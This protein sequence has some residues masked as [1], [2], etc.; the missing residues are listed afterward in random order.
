MIIKVTI[1]EEEKRDILVK[2]IQESLPDG[3]KLTE[4]YLGIG[5]FT[6][7]KN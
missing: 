1:T 5:D 2:H 6:F 7:E 3:Y 4:C